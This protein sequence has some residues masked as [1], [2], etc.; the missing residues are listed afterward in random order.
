MALKEPL[1]DW[2]R[3]N[4]W[5]PIEINLDYL[6]EARENLLTLSMTHEQMEKL[7]VSDLC[8][9][10]ESYIL[11]KKQQLIDNYSAHA[12]LIY[13]WFDEMA[14]SLCVGL[15]SNSPGRTL[16]FSCQ[17]DPFAKLDTVINAFMRSPY[18]EGIPNAELTRLTP[19]DIDVSEAKL[20]E[21]LS[22][23]VTSA[24]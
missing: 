3:D 23:F 15:I 7:T 16:P 1:A 20:T 19:T 4:G 24:P 21:P 8:D 10:V 11:I 18:L 13:V 22:V 12:M 9:F 2:I 17:V 5:N 6:L 14:G